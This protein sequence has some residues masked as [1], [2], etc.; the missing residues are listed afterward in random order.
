[1]SYRVP[2]SG[3]LAFVPNPAESPTFYGK[4]IGGSKEIIIFPRDEWF[5]SLYGYHSIGFNLK[6]DRGWKNLSMT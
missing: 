3:S 1:M 5:V 4:P 2:W 6:K